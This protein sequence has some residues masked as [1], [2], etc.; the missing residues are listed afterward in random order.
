[1]RPALPAI[2]F[3]YL[4]ASTCMPFLSQVHAEWRCPIRAGPWP[5]RVC[6]RVCTYVAC[7]GQGRLHAR[8]G[9]IG[10]VGGGGYW[11]SWL[12]LFAFPI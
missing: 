5:L 1:M 10:M 11:G 6:K 8:S 9:K 7:R 12:F 4:L 2:P 3:G